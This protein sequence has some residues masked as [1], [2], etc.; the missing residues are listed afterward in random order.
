MFDDKAKDSKEKEYQNVASTEM[1][2]TG[3]KGMF[4]FI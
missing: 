2:E 4:A 3:N 1:E